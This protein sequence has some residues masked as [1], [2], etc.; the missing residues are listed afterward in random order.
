[1]AHILLRYTIAVLVLCSAVNAQPADVN[2]DEAKV[3]KYT[4][5]DPLTLRNGEKVAG[6]ET[7]YKRRRPEILQLSSFCTGS[8]V[9]AST[10]CAYVWWAI[11]ATPKT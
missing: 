8:M 5:P 10:R 6:A 9:A 3:P 4:L 2:Y 11:Q 1:M 7:W